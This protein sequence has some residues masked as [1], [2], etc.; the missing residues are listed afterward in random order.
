MMTPEEA[1]SFDR[2][3]IDKLRIPG[4]VL[5]ENAGRGAADAI[6]HFARDWADGNHSA[7]ILCGPGNNG[8]DGFVVARHLWNWGWKVRVVLSCDPESYRGDA[9]KMLL[10]LLRLP[11]EVIQFTQGLANRAA[12]NLLTCVD[13]QPAECIVDA[14]LGIGSKG[15]LRAPIEQMVAIANQANVRRV[16][17]DLPSGFDA[18]AGEPTSTT[19]EADLTCTFIDKKT[20]FGD[21]S[22][23]NFLGLV[24]VIDIGISTRIRSQVI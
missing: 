10:P 4:I 9:R 17:I 18:F 3:A 5:M 16:A 21:S 13:H 1:R 23:A 12:N 19:F 2:F 15:E 6:R 11:I 20:G 24:K 8:G 7:V 22:A 14:L